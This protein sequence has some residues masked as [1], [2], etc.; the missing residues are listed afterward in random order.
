MIYTTNNVNYFRPPLAFARSYDRLS[1]SLS[2][3]EG[4][5]VTAYG[6]FSFSTI[7]HCRNDFH[8]PMKPLGSAMTS[9][10]SNERMTNLQILICNNFQYDSQPI[11]MPRVLQ[12][13]CCW[14]ILSPPMHTINVTKCSIA[15][16]TSLGAHRSQARCVLNNI[17]PWWS[18][19]LLLILQ[20]DNQFDIQLK[21]STIYIL[22]TSMYKYIELICTKI[23]TN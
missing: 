2:I 1:L 16:L 6:G 11:H 20:S 4:L 15:R 9:F 18:L 12:I 22:K 5:Y 8:K 7:C 17:W 23:D 3:T 21:N 19:N 13:P 14:A 10:Q